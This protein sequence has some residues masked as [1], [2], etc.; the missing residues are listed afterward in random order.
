L[1]K[2]RYIHGLFFE[3]LLLWETNQH[4]FRAPEIQFFCH[5]NWLAGISYIIYND[6]PIIIPAFL[7]WFP[8][9]IPIFLVSQLWHQGDL[10][11]SFHRRGASRSKATKLL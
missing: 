2:K 11:H 6:I 1:M 10:L 7:H 9:I 8:I 5:W 4:I 3:G